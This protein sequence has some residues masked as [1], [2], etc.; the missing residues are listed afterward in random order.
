MGEIMEIKDYDNVFEITTE[1]ELERVLS[2][3]HGNGVNE[4]WLSPDDAE[5]PSMAILVNGEMSCVQYFLNKDH[6]GH[7]SN[8]TNEQLSD[9]EYAMFY[10]NSPTEELEI[11]WYQVICFQ[12]ALVAAKEFFNGKL[13]ASIDWEEL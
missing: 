12:A 1:A 10:V 11:C 8:G 13:R 4:F 6:A 7:I 9:D 2:I 3:R 5:F